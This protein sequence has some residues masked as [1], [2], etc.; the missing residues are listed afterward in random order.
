MLVV[1]F[2]ETKCLGIPF[3]ETVAS[4]LCQSAILED[5]IGDGVELREHY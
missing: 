3:V 2:L 4:S 1:G 5:V